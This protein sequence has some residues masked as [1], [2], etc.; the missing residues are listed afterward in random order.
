[1]HHSKIYHLDY[2]EEGA[3]V[4]H[5]LIE[6]DDILVA[7][8]GKFHFALPLDMEKSLCTLIGQWIT[9]LHTNIPDNLYMLRVLTTDREVNPNELE[10]GLVTEEDD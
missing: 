10:S 6:K 7:H 2:F 9:I 4:L 5:E 3:G 8:I 1:L